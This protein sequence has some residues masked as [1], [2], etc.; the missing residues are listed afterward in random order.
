[1]KTINNINNIKD[2]DVY[3]YV[4]DLTLNVTFQFWI[5]MI[6]KSIS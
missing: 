5:C 2:F 4:T 6:F 3:L 1:M